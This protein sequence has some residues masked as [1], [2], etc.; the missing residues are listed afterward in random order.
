MEIS[1]FSTASKP[2]GT[3]LFRSSLSG[4]HVFMVQES[5]V[6]RKRKIG[7][8]LVVRAETKGR[9]VESS[10]ERDGSGGGYRVP[11]MEV[12]TFNQAGFGADPAADFPVWDK[13][14]AVVRLGYGIGNYRIFPL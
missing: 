3:V 9:E 14:G 1:L 7:K 8:C 10:G 6:C 11:A 13:I 4:H 2:P 5:L 12:T